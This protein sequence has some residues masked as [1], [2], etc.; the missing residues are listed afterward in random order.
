MSNLVMTAQP[1]NWRVRRPWRM[2][3]ELDGW[4]AP[5]LAPVEI[6]AGGGSEG[7]AATFE[8]AGRS[9][10][11]GGARGLVARGQRIRAS[12]GRASFPGRLA[13]WPLFDGYVV[14][15]RSEFDGAGR[16]IL[17][18]AIDGVRFRHGDSALSGRH[19]LDSAGRLAF[20]PD[21][22][23]VFNPAG[24]ANR[25]AQPVAINGRWCFVFHGGPA[26]AAFWSAGQIIEYLLAT[27]LAGDAQVE[28]PSAE[29]IASVCLPVA[30]HGLDLSGLDAIEALDRL[31]ALSG[32]AFAI[33]PAASVR[34]GGHW[35]LRWFA[36]TGSRLA[37]FHH[38][39]AGGALT[40]DTNVWSGSLRFEHDS[41]RRAWTAL[42]EP[43]R[44]ESTFALVGGWDP[45]GEGGGHRD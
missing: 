12:L 25:S 28:L 21:L 1:G 35:R 31:A 16:R 7:V 41:A 9:A 8:W 40:A 5:L 18:D 30:P 42:G 13:D 11:F 17:F 29:R 10:D 23:T 3:I 15:V 34:G 32:S 39:R 33:E 4:P 36:A 45:G 14:A 44:V 24:R 43:L 20:A 2:A 26:G 27:R 6:A 19:G 38:G 22:P 37:V